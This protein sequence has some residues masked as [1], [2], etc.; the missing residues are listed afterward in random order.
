MPDDTAVTDADR[1]AAESTR[2]SYCLICTNRP[3]SHGGASDCIYRTM[4]ADADA[5]FIA[6]AMAPERERA[7][8][9]EKALNEIRDYVGDGQFDGMP[10]EEDANHLADLARV[11]LGIM[12]RE[13]VDAFN[14]GTKT[15]KNA[16]GDDG[17][18]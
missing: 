10:F 5:N 8:R 2:N 6:R 14:A 9:M 11:G 1:M 13:E 12:T 4:C 16:E 18:L 17:V 3:R 7:A 15:S